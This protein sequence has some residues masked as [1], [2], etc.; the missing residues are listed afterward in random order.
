M[1]Q[2]R[3]VLRLLLSLLAWAPFGHKAVA[4]EAF[5]DAH[6][7]RM[8]ALAETV[9][10][11]EIGADGRARAV[12]QFMQ[13]VRDYRADAQSDHEYGSPTLRRTPASP[14][15]NYP[16]QIQDL[17]RR[18]GGAFA[19][20]SLTERQR[21]VTEAVV[22][23]RVKN[24]PALPDGGHIA[25]DLMAHFFNGPAANDL[26]YGRSIGRFSCRGLPGS[27]QRPPLLPGATGS[28]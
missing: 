18:A 12:G 15:L 10:P 1:V 9:L 23:A 21:A 3:S 25:T 8:R 2:R 28:P 13:W 17:D 5:G 19:A 26:V 11:R 7:A 20:A 22:A 24:L 27:E 14:A 4:R 16:A 6:A